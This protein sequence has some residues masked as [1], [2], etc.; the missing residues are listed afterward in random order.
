MPYIAS[1][2]SFDLVANESIRERILRCCEQALASG[3]IGHQ[4]QSEL[5]RNFIA[6]NQ[7]QSVE[8]ANALAT[9]RTSCALFVRAIRQWCGASPAGPYVVSTAMFG[10]MG[11]VSFKHPAWLDATTE[12]PRPGDYFYIAS[13]Q[14]SVDGHTGIFIA[15]VS[16]GVW[17][18]A[19]GGGGD[20]TQ[21]RFGQRQIVGSKFAN[22]PRTLWGWFDCEQ[23][24]LPL[25]PSVNALRQV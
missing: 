2:F 15:E 6:C 25:S 13:S 8:K 9:V 22:D 20:G 10:S 23:V 7:E 5:Y 3:P 11:N 12:A 21:C 4:Q 1:Q 16:A 17:K 19:E 14:T 18:T 24:G